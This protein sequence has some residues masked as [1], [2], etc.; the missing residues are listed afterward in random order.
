MRLSGNQVMAKTV[1]RLF[2]SLLT[3][4]LAITAPSARAAFEWFSDDDGVVQV[5]GE[6]SRRVALVNGI[7]ALAATYHGGAWAI[8]EQR[9][10]LFA[11]DGSTV[12]DIDLIQHGYGHGVSLAIDPYDDSVWIATDRSLLLHVSG[13]GE[14]IQGV[15]LPDVA[16]SITVALDRSVWMIANGQVLHRSGD[17]SELDF[18]NHSLVR[19]AHVAV[20]SVRSR[21]WIADAEG[22]KRISLDGEALETVFTSSINALGLDLRSGDVWVTTDTTLTALDAHGQ[23][24]LEIQL[25]LERSE[26]LAIQFDDENARA[27]VR[28]SD[29]LLRIARDGRTNTS[30][31]VDESLLLATSAPLRS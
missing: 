28:L 21:L 15:P 26:R 31:T 7:Q 2:I 4:W 13:T 16:H 18:A 19:A 25:P 24:R 1:T 20:D 12:T 9:L 30:V 17:G 5:S 29:K 11:K 8:S 3:G 10:L 22:L 27:L 6:L 14:L 23:R